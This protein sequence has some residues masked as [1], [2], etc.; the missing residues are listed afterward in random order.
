M[1][2]KQKKFLKELA[3]LCKKYGIST[4]TTKESDVMFVSNTET[5]VFHLFNDNWFTG[6]ST[7]S[8]EYGAEEDEQ[9]NIDG[10]TYC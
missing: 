9:S 3:L 8:K 4:I 2:E 7:T 6:L 1:N 5:L 10:Q